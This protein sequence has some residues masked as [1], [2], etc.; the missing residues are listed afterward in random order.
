MRTIIQ[1]WLADDAHAEEKDKALGEMWER[2]VDYDRAPA[3]SAYRSYDR[4]HKRLGFPAEKAKKT[5]LGGRIVAQIAAALIPF[6]IVAG[7]IGIWKN[8]EQQPAPAQV[9]WVTVVNESETQREILL[10]DSSRVWLNTCTTVAYPESFAGNRTVTLDG[11]AV[12]SVVKNTESPFEVKAGLLSVTVLGTEFNV[13]A[14][15]GQPTTA[16]TLYSGEVL[17]K[18]GALEQ[19]MKPGEKASL[20]LASGELSV[21]PAQ[22]SRPGWMNGELKLQR[23]TLR[24]ILS[25]IERQYG[26]R[27][28]IGSGVNLNQSLAF[29][30][31]GNESLDETMRLLQ[32]V[33]GDIRYTIKQNTIAIEPIKPE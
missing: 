22:E 33:S 5:V 31:N 17:L 19:R 26:V 15:P 23:S 18:S 21:S 16:V 20:D 28:E 30:F 6:L 1:G 7:V 29:P 9:A 10:P 3:P 8:G 12:F 13:E 4:I 27:L 24:T 11:E 25:T 14:Y 2:L 32:Q